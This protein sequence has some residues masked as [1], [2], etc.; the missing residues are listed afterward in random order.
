MCCWLPLRNLGLK[1]FDAC[2]DADLAERQLGVLFPELVDDEQASNCRDGEASDE[3]KPMLGLIDFVGLVEEDPEI[4]EQLASFSIPFMA[5]RLDDFLPAEEVAEVITYTHPALLYILGEKNKRQS[6]IVTMSFLLSCHA[7]ALV[8]FSK[9]MLWDRVA[10]VYADD[11]YSLAITKSVSAKAEDMGLC[12]ESYTPVGAQ[13]FRMDVGNSTAVLVISPPE[14]AQNV[15]RRLTRPSSGGRRGHYQWLFSHPWSAEKTDL[16]AELTGP[17]DVYAV[18]VTPIIVDQFESYWLRRKTP[19][20]PPVAENLWLLEYMVMLKKCRLE[21]IANIAPMD[22]HWLLCHNFNVPETSLDRVLRNTRVLPA[23]H[24]LNAFASAFRKA[25]DSKCGSQNGYCQSLR[26]MTRKEF[27][28][29]VFHPLQLQHASPGNRVPVGFV[30]SKKPSSNKISDVKFSL[31]RSAEGDQIRELFTY[32]K[33]S[34]TQTIDRSFQM[35]PSRCPSNG[36]SDCVYFQSAGNYRTTPEN[37]DDS[38][39]V[40]QDL[41]DGDLLSE[42]SIVSVNKTSNAYDGRVHQN[43]AEYHDDRDAKQKNT[44][45]HPL[46]ITDVIIPALF[47]VHKAGPTPMQCSTEVDPNVIQ[48]VE[49]FLWAL[50]VVNRNTELLNG[51]EIG[52]VV[53]DTCSSP[54][55]AAHLVASVLAKEGDPMLEEINI[56][57]DQLL[58][59][60]SATS[61]EETEA[62]TLMLASNL[63]TTV[64]AKERSDTRLTSAYH[65]QVPVPM[66]VAARAVIDLLNYAGWTYV[67]VVYSSH[68]V[69]AV[70]GFR[71]FQHLAENTQ[72]CVGL[73]EKLN[74]TSRSGPG[75]TSRSLDRVF[76][77][78][79]AKMD[80][81]SRVVVLWTDETD[82]Q[83]ILAK[84]HLLSPEQ[85][86]K[87]RQITWISAASWIAGGK[88]QNLVKDVGRWLVIRPQ[89]Q[90][91]KEFVEH[92]AKLRPENNERNPWYGEYFDQMSQCQQSGECSPVQRIHP[93]TTTVIQTVY[94]VAS[95][96]ARLIQ[97]YCPDQ[98]LLARESGESD[99]VEHLCATN[100]TAFR[101]TLLAY[102]QNTGTDRPGDV[103]GEFGFTDQGYG[104]TPLEI[105]EVR[106]GF[107]E[108]TYIPMATYEQD[109]LHFVS[110]GSSEFGNSNPIAEN[111]LSSI[112]ECSANRKE[113]CAS[114]VAK[115]QNQML[116]KSSKDRLYVMGLF[117]VRERSFD[118]LWSCS[119]NVTTRGIQQTE[120]LYDK[121][122]KMT[123][124]NE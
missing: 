29:D 56:D 16:L 110:N 50:D 53:F 3:E 54:A 82:T 85:A 22:P 18:A 68:D 84:M 27:L 119:T 25:R 111:L 96:V 103:D 36:C 33:S 4:G 117:D 87:F 105:V 49:A 70:T 7:Q 104:D 78:L 67:S 19:V 112:S 11:D 80:M 118:G 6:L 46:K 40:E 58:A 88:V 41:S 14:D 93:S 37:D 95:G 55:K 8:R 34:G 43:R 52:A 64:S 2:G 51:I 76:D 23:V 60:V 69:D 45:P 31:I 101:D 89:V 24:V 120:V 44:Q 99:D 108:F 15:T 39:P 42:E 35:K 61:G 77:Q 97:D 83:S 79:I 32:H 74:R 91:V 59:V 1:I 28:D 115:Q 86:D 20:L 114:C 12:L 17:S 90:L 81:G 73:A 124:E 109:V 123:G 100:T 47:A 21:A 26:E 116:I 63:I 30:G 71:H 65:L 38:K 66:S 5:V 62:A 121:Q 122:S 92:F 98:Q 94:V 72:I 102:L 113:V 9:Q 106:G 107:S 13:D 10:V 75:R 48:D 57:P